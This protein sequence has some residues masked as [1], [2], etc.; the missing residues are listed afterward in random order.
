VKTGDLAKL[1]GV[2]QT[3]ITRWIDEFSDFMTDRA[4]KIGVSQRAYTEADILALATVAKL[5]VEDG[6]RFPQIKERM[7]AGERVEHPGVANFGVDHRVVPAQAVENLVDAS[8]LRNELEQVKIERDRLIE[9]VS[10]FEDK[11]EAVRAEKDGKIEEFQSRI[12][13]LQ[14][15]LGMAEGELTYRRE[16]DKHR[17][18]DTPD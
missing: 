8:V 2:S 12:A 6:L 14:H 15:R 10:K 13:E 11:I 5:S 4:Q 16:L 1:F 9:L 17:R 3:T 7:Q 18:D